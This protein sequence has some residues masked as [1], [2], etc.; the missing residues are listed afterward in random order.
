M[1]GTHSYWLILLAVIVANTGSGIRPED[2]AKV[3]VAF[4]QVD[5]TAQRRQEGPGLGLH[6]SQKLAE[7]LGGRIECRSK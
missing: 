3:F 5:P 7:V 2:Q 4:T 6:L 1:A